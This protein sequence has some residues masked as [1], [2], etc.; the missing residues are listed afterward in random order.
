MLDKRFEWII[1]K[2]PI[3]KTKIRKIGTLNQINGFF[4][5]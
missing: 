2:E 4:G 1:L 5:E 3:F